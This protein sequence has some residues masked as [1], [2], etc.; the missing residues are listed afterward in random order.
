MNIILDGKL[1]QCILKNTEDFHEIVNNNSDSFGIDEDLNDH[2]FL[3]FVCNYLFNWCQ[4]GVG[5]AGR[6]ESLYALM[7]FTKEDK[8]QLTEDQLIQRVNTQFGNEN[9]LFIMMDYFGR[10]M[11]LFDHGSSAMSSWLN[12][13]GQ[14]IFN[15][16]DKWI[17]SK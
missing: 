10:D 15:Y 16:L 12:A 11:G 2:R 17:K 14:I 8:S 4:C 5:H 7:E 13:D 6:L 3:S 1:A 9:N